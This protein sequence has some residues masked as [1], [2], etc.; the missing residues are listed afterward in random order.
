MNMHALYTGGIRLHTFY[1]RSGLDVL[2]IYIDY[3]EGLALSTS[4]QKESNRLTEIHV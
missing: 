1:R 3:H 4:S 2:Y